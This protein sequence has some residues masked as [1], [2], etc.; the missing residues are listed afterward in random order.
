[1]EEA[2]DAKLIGEAEGETSEHVHAAVSTTERPFSE[3]VRPYACGGAAHGGITLIETCSCGAS[4]SVNVNGRHGESGPWRM[5]ETSEDTDA[6]DEEASKP[7]CKLRIVYEH[8]GW[9]PFVVFGTGA[10]TRID[11]AVARAEVALYFG[12]KWILDKDGYLAEL[13][14]VSGDKRVFLCPEEFEM[15]PEVQP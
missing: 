11:Q 15:G 1:M 4:R 3:C 12:L 9:T 6:E 7:V 8:G 14:I 5:P 2:Y 10:P 13:E